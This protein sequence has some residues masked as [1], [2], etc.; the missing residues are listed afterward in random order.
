MAK[1]NDVLDNPFLNVN[2]ILIGRTTGSGRNI[3][4]MPDN[5]E[6]H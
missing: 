1:K 5:S 2:S 6:Y 3:E 4:D